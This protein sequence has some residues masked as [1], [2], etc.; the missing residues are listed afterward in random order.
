MIRVV[1]RHHAN[2]DPDLYLLVDDKG[3]ELSE[4]VKRV[5]NRPKIARRPRVRELVCSQ[6][7]WQ[8]QSCPCHCVSLGANMPK[9][10]GSLMLLSGILAMGCNEPTPPVAK[11]RSAEAEPKQ[12]SFVFHYRFRVKDLESS[13]DAASELVRVWLPCPSNTDCQEVKRLEATAPAELAEHQ[14]ARFGNRVLYMETPIP[15]SGGFSVDVP[16][17]VVRHEVLQKETDGDDNDPLD[18]ELRAKLLAADQ[19]VPI[20]GPP[21]AMLDSLQLEK[22][23]LALARQLYEVVDEHVVYKKEGTGWGRGDTEWV[24]QSGYGNCTDFHSLFISLARS[25]GL[26][27][28][29]EIGFS[30]PNDTPEGPVAGYHCWAWFFLE[31]RGWIPVD[32]SEADKH[33]ELREYYF[34]NLTADRVMF[35]QGRDLQLTPKSAQESLNFF[36]YPHIEIADQPLPKEKLELQFSYTKK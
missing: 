9:F 25:Q 8:R 35:S 16:Y 22:E 19:L 13:G 30:I 20:S 34:G 27:S 28:R 29:F 24:C 1:A 36:I 14:E 2:N 15:P 6:I 3:L 11:S 32:I 17:E 4:N 18:Q 31:G 5:L 21:L 7:F 33:P 23:P 26:P 12:R 10:F